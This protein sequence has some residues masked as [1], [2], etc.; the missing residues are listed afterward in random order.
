MTTVTKAANLLA[1]SFR[2]RQRLEALPQDCR[3]AGLEVA[4]QIQDALVERLLAARGGRP[5]GYKV[6]CTNVSAQRLLGLD[7]PFHGRLLSPF[8]H[9]SPARLVAGDLFMRVIEP[10]FAFAMGK[11]LPAEDG[12]Y[13]IERVAAAVGALLPAV[14]VVDSRYAQWTSVGA[15]S[16][17]ADNGATGA[18]VT[19]T[20]RS[21]WQSFDLA[22]HE[23]S[24]RV[25]GELL[26]SGRGEAVMG[27]PMHALTWLANALSKAGRGLLAG[28]MVSTGVC[29]EVY[30]AAPGDH[31]EADYGEFGKVAV[32]FEQADNP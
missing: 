3:P 29:M 31:V 18:W 15:P 9:S 5:V 1:E 21:D 8:V 10:E 13:G 30:P 11:D 4:Y 22:A 7:G 6:G 17:V 26:R 25:N 19:G 24:L 28:E 20:P 27:H 12:P 16:L 2:S 32:T 14:E 23:V